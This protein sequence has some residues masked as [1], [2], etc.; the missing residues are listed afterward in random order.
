METDMET[1]METGPFAARPLGVHPDSLVMLKRPQRRGLAGADTRRI[2]TAWQWQKCAWCRRFEV[3]AWGMGE[4]AFS[5]S[6]REK[7]LD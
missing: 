5:A 6:A 7:S 3:P 2:T 4:R 1:D